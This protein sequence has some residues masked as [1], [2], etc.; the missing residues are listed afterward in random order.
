MHYEEAKARVECI[1]PTDEPAFEES[2]SIEDK[3]DV[4]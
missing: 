1:S 2:M 4:V 3:M